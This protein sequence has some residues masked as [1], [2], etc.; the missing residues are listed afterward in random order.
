MC[1][2]KDALKETTGVLSQ[3]GDLF[4]WGALGTVLCCAWGNWIPSICP[5][6]VSARAGSG[7]CGCWPPVCSSS[8]SPS[9]ITRKVVVAGVRLASYQKSH[10]AARDLARASSAALRFVKRSNRQLIWFCCYSALAA[11]SARKGGGRHVDGWREGPRTLWDEPAAPLAG[12]G[13]CWLTGRELFYIYIYKKK[14]ILIGT[15][16]NNKL[17][18]FF[19]FKNKVP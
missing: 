3:Q 6:L 5:F 14:K 19:F 16:R 4:P 17:W 1:L 9:P 10:C 8:F 11:P 12:H 7:L 2:V 13:C 18:W 15:H